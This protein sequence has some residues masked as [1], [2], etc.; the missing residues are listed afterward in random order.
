MKKLLAPLLAV[1][2]LLVLT[3]GAAA[4]GRDITV[5]VNGEAVAWTDAKPFV[6]AGGR[7]MVPLRPVAAA[8][9]LETAWDPV[10]RAASFT[11][12]GVAYNGRCPWTATIVF[13]VGKTTATATSSANWVDS[14][15]DITNTTISMDTAA[16]VVG[17]RTYAPVRYLAEYFHFTVGWDSAARTVS[18]TRDRPSAAYVPPAEYN[19]INLLLGTWEADTELWSQES[20]TD[21]G[22]VQSRPYLVFCEDGKMAYQHWDTLHEGTY[23]LNTADKEDV[24]AVA[25]LDNGWKLTLRL[26]H[27]IMD[28]DGLPPVQIDYP[29]GRQTTTIWGFYPYSDST[30]YG[31]D[32][33]LE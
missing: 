29:A 11:Q 33:W 22:V 7:T 30:S 3:S 13:P 27:M 4:A 9:G 20:L 2:L 5:L 12:T 26:Y 31:V 1:L 10:S 17:G 15:P 6:N 24:Y 23:L 19:G 18:I 32:P 28:A 21:T 14:E 25:T 8:M 16:V